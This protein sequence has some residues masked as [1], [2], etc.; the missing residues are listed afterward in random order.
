MGGNDE[1][2]VAQPAHFPKKFEKLQLG[3]RGK[4]CLRLIQEVKPLN[5]IARFKKR[6]DGLAVRLG[7]QGFPAEILN[8]SGIVCLPY[9][10]ELGEVA[11]D[12]GRKERSRHDAVVPFDFEIEKKPFF[13]MIDHSTGSLLSPPDVN[14]ALSGQSL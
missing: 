3:L 10:Y 2:G 12:L 13:I 7:Q 5:L 9:I 11:K 4:G 14:L 8:L 1:L 6:H